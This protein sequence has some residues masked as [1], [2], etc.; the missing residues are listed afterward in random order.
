AGRV[1]EAEERVE[2]ARDREVEAGRVVARDRAGARE[3]RD[4]AAGEDE[5]REE[6]ERVG[7]ADLGE[8]ALYA[9]LGEAPGEQRQVRPVRAD[10]PVDDPR[11]AQ[12]PAP[13]ARSRAGS[14]GRRR[15]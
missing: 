15:W 13:P 6:G 14:S 9:G 11:V 3:G 12:R 4:L 1:G 2:R 10:T 5:V 8:V 7:H